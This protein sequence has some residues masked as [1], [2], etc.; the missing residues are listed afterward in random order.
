M[1]DLFNKLKHGLDKGVTAAS[2][3]S[4]EVIESTKLKSQIRDLQGRKRE[5]LEELGNIVYAM[6]LQGSFDEARVREKAAVVAA[7]DDHIKQ[8]EAEV[9]DVHVKAQEA[10]GKPRM[11]GVCACGAELPVGAKFCG[12]C[13]RQI[14]AAPAPPPETGAANLCPGCGAALNPGT[15]FCGRCGRQV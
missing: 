8:K 11:A 4:K 12:K 2:A 15:K 6:F 3:K 13:G 10:M 5:V 14:E 9:E 1:A 7:V